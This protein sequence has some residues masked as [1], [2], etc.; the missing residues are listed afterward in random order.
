MTASDLSIVAQTLRQRGYDARNLGPVGIT[1]WKDGRGLF[2]SVDQI[3]KLNGNLA[4]E[5]ET[6]LKTDQRP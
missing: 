1:V 3:A 5:V 6:L 2:L 4:S